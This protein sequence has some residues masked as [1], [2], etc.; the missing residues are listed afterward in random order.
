MRV[1][2]VSSIPW[3]AQQAS[4]VP[5]QATYAPAQTTTFD[6]SSMM[7][8]MMMLMFM[9]MMIKMIGQATEAFG[10]QA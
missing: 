1:Q 9:V 6:M 4:F 5:A 2:Q 8:M 3:G 10:K 7:N